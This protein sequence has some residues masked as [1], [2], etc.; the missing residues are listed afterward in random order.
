MT[1]R[2]T[3]S[4]AT[5]PQ[6]NALT[7]TPVNAPRA[8]RDRPDGHPGAPGSGTVTLNWVAPTGTAPTG[9]Q[10]DVSPAGGT[11][12]PPNPIPAGATTAQVTGL[13]PGSYTFTV[14]PLHPAPFV[15]QAGIDRTGQPDEC[16]D[17]DPGRHRHPSH[18]CHRADPD[19]RQERR[20][21]GRHQRHGRLPERHP[22]GDRGSWSGH[23]ADTGAA[24]GGP[25]DGKFTEY[26]YP[27]NA[28]GTPNPTYPTHC[29][30][31]LGIAKLI[32]NGPGRGQFFAASGV[33]NQVTVVDT[34]DT[35]TGWGLTGTMSTFT[36]TGDVTKTFSGSQLGW[37]PVMTDDSDLFTDSGGVSY[38][39][40]VLPG[41]VVAPNS[42]NAS[43]LSTGKTL[44]SAAGLAGSSPTFTGGLGMAELDARLKLLIP[45]TEVSGVYTGT[46][47]M[48]VA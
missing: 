3:N 12:T 25:A 22:A 37:N 32:K 36:K 29:G 38:D 40:L 9:Y 26:P 15:A 2:A 17:P 47:T 4:P 18:G 21:P 46:L 30:I 35:D 31:N 24:P 34:R 39:Q 48:T 1:V 11:V 41:A 27:E 7:G 44:G 16:P 19:L 42:P 23:G 43:G 8:R 6:S 10:V 5:A 45:V 13:T 20:H 33:L 14:T 28:D